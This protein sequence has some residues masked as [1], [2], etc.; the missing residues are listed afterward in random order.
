MVRCQAA[1]APPGGRGI[2]CSAKRLEFF[3]P[4]M[5]V[6]KLLLHSQDSLG[7]GRVGGSMAEEKTPKPLET[8][9]VIFTQFFSSKTVNGKEI[10]LE[11][12]TC[13]K[14]CK[15]HVNHTRDVWSQANFLL[16]AL[17]GGC[18]VCIGEICGGWVDAAPSLGPP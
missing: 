4:K 16:N 1:F 2:V 9:M 5:T 7:G 18:S 15:P 6:N 14:K 17:Q 13:K 3:D 8:G 12:T 10:G 11:N